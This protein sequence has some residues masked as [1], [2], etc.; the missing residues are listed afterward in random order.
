[1]G[2]EG[3]AFKKTLLGSAVMAGELLVDEALAIKNDEG[4]ALK[5][6]LDKLELRGDFE[7]DLDDVEYFIEAHVEQGP[8]LHYERIPIGI[9]ENMCGL[10]CPHCGKSLLVYEE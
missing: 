10:V 8:I 3:S 9:V 1:M 2:E 5:E 7:M 4:I 6:A